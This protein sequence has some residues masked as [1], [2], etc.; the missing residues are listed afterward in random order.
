M[1]PWLFI[2]ACLTAALLLEWW[3]W[4]HASKHNPGPSV[5]PFWVDEEPDGEFR[6]SLVYVLERARGEVR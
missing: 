4:R 5:L 2:L 6:P 1:N 3:D